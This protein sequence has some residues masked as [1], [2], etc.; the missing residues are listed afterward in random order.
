MHI[1]SS[2]TLDLYKTQQS[3]CVLLQVNSQINLL[4][5]AQNIHLYSFNRLWMVHLMQKRCFLCARKISEA[6]VY[7]LNT[8]THTDAWYNIIINEIRSLTLMHNFLMRLFP[9][10]KLKIF[11]DFLFVFLFLLFYIY[12][13]HHHTFEWHIHIYV[14]SCCFSNVF[15]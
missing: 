10:Y 5:A 2:T 3:V 8:H 4:A 15:I 7:L 1:K 11:L 9:H 14:P 13:C 12:I 6:K